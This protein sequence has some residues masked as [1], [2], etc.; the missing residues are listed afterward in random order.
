[1]DEQTNGNNESNYTEHTDEK[2]VMRDLKL[3]QWVNV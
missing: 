1:M 3:T 2:R